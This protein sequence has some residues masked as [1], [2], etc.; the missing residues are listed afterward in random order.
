MNT[1]Q[2]IQEKAPRNRSVYELLRGY[3]RNVD[4]PFISMEEK[5]FIEDVKGLAKELGIN[6][7]LMAEKMSHLLCGKYAIKLIGKLENNSNERPKRRFNFI[8]PAG[9]K[10]DTL[11]PGFVATYNKLMRLKEKGIEYQRVRGGAARSVFQ[12]VQEELIDTGLMTIEE[13]ES[14]PMWAYQKFDSRLAKAFHN[15]AQNMKT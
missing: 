11:E 4:N 5:I 12:W 6:E 3:G 7:L 15:K 2:D 14:L 8:P 10:I 13:L 9:Q 1:S